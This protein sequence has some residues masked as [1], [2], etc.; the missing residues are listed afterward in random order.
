MDNAAALLMA[1]GLLWQGRGRS[2]VSKGG[3]PPLN[4]PSAATGYLANV[5]PRADGCPGCIAPTVAGLAR[6]GPS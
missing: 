4:L 1:V 6:R 3:A 5:M 2:L